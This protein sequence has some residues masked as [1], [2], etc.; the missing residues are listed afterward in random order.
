MRNQHNAGGV[1]VEVHYPWAWVWLPATHALCTG[2]DPD[3]EDGRSRGY[4]L[5]EDRWDLITQAICAAVTAAQHTPDGPCWD[6]SRTVTVDVDLTDTEADI[7]RSW[8]AMGDLNVRLTANADVR[9]ETVQPAKAHWW[10]RRPDPVH[11][12]VDC[13][14]MDLANGRHR[15]WGVAS[16]GNTEPLPLVDESFTYLPG[17]ADHRADFDWLFQPQRWREHR[18][19]WHL[20]SPEVRALNPTFFANLDQLVRDSVEL[21]FREVS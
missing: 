17:A 19:L 7:V 9:V 4:D 14:T 18:D 10:S 21:T 15:L 16:A 3:R 13:L 1:E 8:V 20:A 2:P 11:E 5:S 12:V 6:V